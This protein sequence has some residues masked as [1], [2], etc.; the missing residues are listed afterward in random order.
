M[1]THVGAIGFP[2]DGDAFVEQ[3]RRLLQVAQPMGSA[4]GGRVRLFGYRDPSGSFATVTIESD[5]LT[6]FTPGLM[7][8][9]RLRATCGVLG[10]D[11]CRYER[12][13]MIEAHL[14]DMDIP[15]AITIDDLALS[16]V[17]YVPGA[18]I[19]LEVAALAE[20]A[21]WFD[22][23]E[24]FRASG[25][26]MAVESLIPSGLFSV[27]ADPDTWQVSSRIL[28]TGTVVEAALRRHQLFDHPFAILTVRSLGG[29][30]RVAID[31]DDLDGGV[32]LPAPGAVFS[33]SLWLSGH[34]HPGDPKEA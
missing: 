13:L 11:A 23:V 3:T 31:V 32:S 26:P 25:T 8:G 4:D 33:G 27:G 6:C 24:A 5:A 21:T 7:P 16:E 2:A 18:E 28:L 14:T 17:A 29:E 12:P 20:S 22:D 10:D 34:L 1:G 9:L 15:L 30:W 19:E